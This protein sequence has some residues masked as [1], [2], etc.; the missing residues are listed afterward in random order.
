MPGNCNLMRFRI[1][2]GWMWWTLFALLAT[3]G[4]MHPIEVRASPCSAAA[5]PQ[6]FIEVRRDAVHEVVDT[7]GAEL[8]RIAAA[9]GHRGHTPAFGLYSA[10]LSY[11]AAISSHVERTGADAYCA[12]PSSVRIVVML[13]NRVI[14]L[15][16][17]LKD[18]QCLMKATFAHVIE[19]ARADEQVIESGIAGFTHDM[20]TSLA[21]LQISRA[22][23]AETARIQLVSMISQE[24]EAQINK[25]EAARKE[26]NRSLDSPANLAKLHTDCA[27]SKADADPPSVAHTGGP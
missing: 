24:V 16:A 22:R 1:R 12:A 17:E 9:T 14:H 3:S 25:L 15:A 10:T 27:K 8:D 21:H 6:L 20:R 26:R 13:S 19:H 7:S 18:N 5:S 4:L 11:K 23:S 2:S